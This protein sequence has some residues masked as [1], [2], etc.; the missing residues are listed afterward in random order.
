MCLLL[1]VCSCVCTY[2]CVS[3]CECNRVCVCLTFVNQHNLCAFMRELIHIKR[4]DIQI[5][6]TR[7]IWLGINI[8]HRV[9]VHVMIRTNHR[10]IN[11][12]AHH[13]NTIQAVASKLFTNTE[14]IAIYIYLYLLVW[15]FFVNISF[16]R[17]CIFLSVLCFCLFLYS[18]HTFYLNLS[19]R[20]Y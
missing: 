7:F 18:L 11:I 5:T 19:Y 3:L 9:V 6:L 1:C 15:L 10:Q 2:F 4:S 17:F 14:A 13:P 20:N 12:K 16:F 8:I